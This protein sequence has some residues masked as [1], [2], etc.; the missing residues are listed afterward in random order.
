MPKKSLR[1]KKSLIISFLVFILIIVGTLSVMLLSRTRQDNRQQAAV[2]NGLIK[3]SFEP[4]GN[5]VAGAKCPVKVYLNTGDANIDGLQLKFVFNQAQI[6]WLGFGARKIAAFSLLSKTIDQDKKEATMV[7]TLSNPQ[8][9]YKT[10]NNKVLLGTLRFKANDSMIDKPLSFNLDQAFS[11]ATLYQT[12]Q[13]SLNKTIAVQ[14]IVVAKTCKVDKDCKDNEFCNQLPV[15]DEA[16][17]EGEEDC[18]PSKPE[19]VCTAKLESCAY[20][21]SD[22]SECK[23][24]KQ[25]RKVLNANQLIC[26]EKPVLQ[27]FCVPTCTQECPSS[28]NVLKDCVKPANNGTARQVLCNQSR[29]VAQC[30]GQDFCCPKA[31]EAWTKDMSVCNAPPS[32]LQSDFNGDGKVN[33]KDLSIMIKQLFS[34]DLTF[35]LSKDGKVDIAD[36]SLFIKDFVEAQAE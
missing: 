27:Q 24:G 29:K 7:W 12:G 13:D 21:Y 26:N 18:E 25:T 23:E 32:Y 30:G 8:N 9:A 36:Y 33:G 6:S 17:C 2:D 20:Q 15:T 31:G 16:D 14:T 22:W 4:S 35:D 10:K 11:K 5:C 3:V 1:S 19:K 28:D 34:T